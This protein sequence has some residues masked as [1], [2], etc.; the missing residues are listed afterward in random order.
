MKNNF[1]SLAC[2][3]ALTLAWVGCNKAGKLS[4]HSEWK[5]PAG[6]VALTLKW[7]LGERVEQDMDMQMKNVVTMPGQKAPLQQDMNMG[8]HYGLTVLQTNADGSHEVEMEFLSTKMEMKMGDKVQMSY[9]SS[10][11]EES[12]KPNPLA[13]AFKQINGSKIRY[14]LNASNGVD[15]IEGM[16]ELYD[17]MSAGGK[18]NQAAPLKGMLSE[19][20]YKQLMLS[21]MFL[22]TNAVQPTDT[23]NA[24]LE[25][26]AGVMGTIIMNYDCTFVAWEMHGQRNCARIDFQGTISQKPS[27]KPDD[28]AMQMSMTIQDS[29]STG[30]LWFDPELGLI[31]D[32]SMTQDINMTMHMTMGGKGKAAKP[33]TFTNQ[34]T[35]A[36]SIKLVSVK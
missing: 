8:Q 2:L 28:G 22:P 21:Y 31:I 30:S 14:F 9:D 29:S 20:N 1:R 17:K 3:L 11:K 13:E 4:Q 33:Q 18:N 6:P 19:D 7:P 12:G 36:V 27:D 10:K 16:N 24:H 15:R 34:M 35:Q 25:L 26:P 23:W 5:P 32:T